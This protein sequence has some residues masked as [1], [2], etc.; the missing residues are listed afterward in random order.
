M[1]ASRL[2]IFTAADQPRSFLSCSVASASNEATYSSR[3]PESYPFL[4]RTTPSARRCFASG[5]FGSEFSVSELGRP[6]RATRYSRVPA[7]GQSPACPSVRAISSGLSSASQTTWISVEKPP[8]LRPSAFLCRVSGLNKRRAARE[9]PPGVSTCGHVRVCQ[10]KEVLS[11]VQKIGPPDALS[12]Y[13]CVTNRLRTY[14]IFRS[15][16]PASWGLNRLQYR[17]STVPPCFSH[18]R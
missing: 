2:A 5:V 1:I 16:V 9:H 18:K 6:V 8:R 12:D 15:L 4:P 7:R 17:K 11:I 3:S 13:L 14:F 10:E